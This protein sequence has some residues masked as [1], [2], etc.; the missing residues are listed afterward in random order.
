[1]SPK[2]FAEYMQRELDENTHKGCWYD[3]T[4]TAAQ[5]NAELEHHRYKLSCA[6]SVG[7]REQVTEF[8]A[9]VANI[10]MKIAELFGELEQDAAAPPETKG[11]KGAS[12]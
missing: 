10:A 7:T 11:S 9:D 2:E 8:A 6:L 5:A 4:P 12:A 1:M 3:W